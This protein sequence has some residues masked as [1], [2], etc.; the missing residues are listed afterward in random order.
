MMRANK[1]RSAARR[2]PWLNGVVG[3]GLVLAG[4]A[5]PAGAPDGVD[6]ERTGA[7]GAE[8]A[9]A[10]VAQPVADPALPPSAWIDD[11]LRAPAGSP[12]GASHLASVTCAGGESDCGGACQPTGAACTVGVGACAGA[13]T[14]VCGTGAPD[15]ASSGSTACALGAGGTVQC[16][17]NNAN[18]AL[19]DGTTVTRPSPVRVTGLRG[20]T[21]VTVGAYHAC[22]LLADATVRCWG[23]NSNGQLGDGTTTQR[24]TPVA[25]SGLA[26]VSRI[27][28]GAYFTCALLADGTARCWGLNA[29]GQLG[30]GTVTRRLAPVPVAGLAGVTQLAAGV[31]HAC[32]LLADGSARCWGLNSNGQLGDGG[33]VQRL[34]PGPVAGLAGATALAAGAAFTCALGAGGSASCWGLNSSGQLGDGTVTR[35]LVPVAVAGLTGATQLAAGAAHAC[36][37]Q[38]DGTAR[39]WGSNAYGQVGDGTLLRRTAPVAVP[40]LAGVVNVVAA[41]RSTCALL[42]G[43]AAQCWGDGASGQLGDGGNAARATPGAVVG[44]DAGTTCSATPGA[45]TTE[46]CDGVDNDCNGAVDDVAPTACAPGACATRGHL[47]CGAGPGFPTICV[48]DV[49][50]AAGFVCRAAVAGGCDVAESCDGVS[51]ACPADVVQTAGTVC[52]GAGGVC[53]TAEV[54]TGTANTCPADALQ[55]AGTVCRPAAAGGCDVAEACTG[56]V[57]ICP[58]DRYLPATAVC[59]AAAGPCDAPETCRGT[60]SACP[61][62]ALRPSTYACR[63]AVPGGCDVTELCTGGAVACPADAVRLAG[64]SCRPELPGGCDVAEVCDGTANMCPANVVR[65]AGTTCRLANGVCDV[66]EVCNG[67]VNA[68]PADAFLP[69]TVVCRL[70]VGD[71]DAAETCTG[72]SRSCPANALRPAGAVCRGAVGPCDVAETCTGAS[73]AC[74]AAVIAA[75]GTP[76]RPAAGACDAAEVCDGAA[77]S[78]P[79]DGA[80]ADRTAC[81]DGDPCTRA[82][83]CSAGACVGGARLDCDDGNACTADACGATCLHTPIAGCGS[84]A[85][86]VLVPPNPPVD[87]AAPTQES[88]GVALI[89]PAGVVAP[90]A[91]GASALGLSSVEVRG[92]IAGWEFAPA[93]ALASPVAVRVPLDATPNGLYA[94]VGRVGGAWQVESVARV[95]ADG[96][97]AVASLARLGQH[98]LVQLPGCDAPR[99]AQPTGGGTVGDPQQ[100]APSSHVLASESGGTWAWLTQGVY[101][102]VGGRDYFVEEGPRS[103]DEAGARM[104]GDGTWLAYIRGGIRR[105]DVSAL[106]PWET[107][108]FTTVALPEGPEGPWQYDGLAM[109]W[110]GRRMVFIARHP[111]TGRSDLF[112]WEG[113]TAVRPLTSADGR[114]GSV[115]LNGSAREVALSAD[116]RWMSFVTDA[117]DVVPSF[118]EAGGVYL[119]DLQTGDTTLVAPAGSVLSAGASVSRSGRL[120]AWLAPP[121]AD[122]GNNRLMVWDR[123]TGARREVNRDADGTTRWVDQWSMSNDGVRFVF[124]TTDWENVAVGV[125][126]RWLGAA[127]STP[128]YTGRVSPLFGEVTGERPVITGNGD[129]VFSSESGHSNTPARVVW[130]HR[131]P[132]DAIP[133]SARAVPGDRWEY[134]PFRAEWSGFSPFNARAAFAW[135]PATG[136]STRVPMVGDAGDAEVAAGLPLGRHPLVTVQS[137]EGGDGVGVCVAQADFQVG[138]ARVQMLSGVGTSSYPNLTP[139]FEAP[140]YLQPWDGPFRLSSGARYL[141]PFRDWE[142]AAGVGAT[143]SFRR[144]DRRGG[145]RQNEHIEGLSVDSGP[146]SRFALGASVMNPSGR[147]A[148]LEEAD[149]STVPATSTKYFVDLASRA[150]TATYRGQAYRSN[151]AAEV[152]LSNDGTT[153]IG[154][155]AES[156]DDVIVAWQTPIAPVEIFRRARFTGHG[157]PAYGAVPVGD[158]TR[159]LFQDTFSTL[160]GNPRYGHNELRWWNRDLASETLLLSWPD[161][162]VQNYP[163]QCMSAST[164]LAQVASDGHWVTFCGPTPEGFPG[165]PA[166]ECLGEQG[167]RWLYDIENNVLRQLSGT[168]EDEFDHPPV[169]ARDGALLVYVDPAA[170]GG[171]NVVVY[172]LGLHAARVAVAGAGPVRG[173]RVN[174]GGTHVAFTTD[175]RAYVESHGLTWPSGTATTAAVLAPLQDEYLGAVIPEAP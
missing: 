96:T 165:L 127:S 25:V 57:K 31:S 49:L 174:L 19:G 44:L 51:A 12:T 76:C 120:V 129:Y 35:R 108:E 134:E 63:P 87:T 98:A 139:R 113:G 94:V 9:A 152:Q 56:S 164:P 79:A 112:L 17:G 3:A 60:S 47:S 11:R 32:A 22:A 121:D 150:V 50:R 175:S 153:A 171:S 119:R 166:V 91:F 133:G 77:T 54:C 157:I 72:A 20:V 85:A 48:A 136:F 168:C 28:A 18:G 6:P 122:D 33:V 88:S 100:W 93:G 13:G 43:G 97:H 143:V 99:G 149:T 131:V 65:P 132:T 124:S 90:G 142:Q 55:A 82:D 73:T 83:A 172:D 115:A 140:L 66:A 71:C 141:I 102:H 80:A 37:A 69:A 114:E 162:V 45:P 167:A 24:L 58:A 15:L 151:F 138:R 160:T 36:A 67:V 106:I 29:N 105:Y 14:V 27:V 135:E 148:F 104:S 75:A 170:G 46:V 70:A 123:A 74:P 137:F 173:L 109:S 107:F 125:R 38:G 7:S 40:G 26:G 101:I 161:R 95:T 146:D 128:L 16:W 53:D 130:R 118:S 41:D 62:D 158:G 30:D 154:R 86:E 10:P 1:G 169:F 144:F 81:E 111:V 61:A 103:A 147:R 145:E 52:R 5:G 163:T 126:T 116:G 92:L 34:V 42:M 23:R 78:C 21:A 155:Y 59:R 89:D 39:C 156:T 68:C 159:V 110:D 84:A 2:R 4:C 8:R 117:T 64:T